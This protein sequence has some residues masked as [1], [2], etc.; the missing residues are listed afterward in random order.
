MQFTLAEAMGQALRKSFALGIY[1]KMAFIRF[2]SM[3]ATISLMRIE[4]NNKI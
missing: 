1:N 3:L 4:L 2:G